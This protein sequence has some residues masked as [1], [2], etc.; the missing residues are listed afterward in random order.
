MT[1]V[2]VVI[3]AYNAENTI[4]ETVDSVLSQTQDAVEVIVVDDGSSDTTAER[5]QR[6]DSVTVI[7]TPNRGVSA[8]R[9]EG[10]ERARGRFVAFLDAD[11][12]WEPGKLKRQ[13]E[14]LDRTPDAVMCVSGSRLLGEGGATLETLTPWAS[15]D[16]PRDLLL[17]SMVLGHVISVLIRRDQLA[18]IGGFDSRFSQCADWDFFLRAT[19]A[20]RLARVPDPL[21]VIRRD[22]PSMSSNIELLERDTFGVLDEFFSR[23]ESEPYQGLKRQAYSNHWMILSGS[24]LHAGDLRAS[25]RCLRAGLRL[26]PANVRRPLGA[27]SRW[28]RRLTRQERREQHAQ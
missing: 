11:D 28:L 1:Q 15:D 7:R 27:P 21:V 19:A 22:R 23:P 9:N 6:D 20:G 14:V 2:S 12:L 13:V 16:P 18:Q 3:P 4:A 10:I 25:L 26:H 17:H 24:Y 5:A 8:A